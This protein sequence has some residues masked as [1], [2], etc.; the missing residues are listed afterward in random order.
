MVSTIRSEY[1]VNP[2]SLD[3][4]CANDICR[5]DLSAAQLLDVSLASS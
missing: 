5:I 1:L 4:P 2:L 3:C